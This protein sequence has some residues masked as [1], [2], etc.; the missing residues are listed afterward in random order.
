M[1]DRETYKECSKNS[2][3]FFRIKIHLFSLIKC[4]RIYRGH[5]TKMIYQYS[6][7]FEIT[8]GVFSTMLI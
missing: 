4:Y 8:R 7:T 6:G 1:S 3:R 5:L 2:T